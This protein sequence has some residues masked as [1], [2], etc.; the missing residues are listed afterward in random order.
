MASH[1]YKVRYVWQ[2]DQITGNS[3]NKIDLENI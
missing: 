1:I 2:H 3:K